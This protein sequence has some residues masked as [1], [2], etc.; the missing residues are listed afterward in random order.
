MHSKALSLGGVFRGWFLFMLVTGPLWLLLHHYPCQAFLSV[1]AAAQ[2]QRRQQ[3]FSAFPFT[4]FMVEKKTVVVMMMKRSS[5]MSSSSKI[6]DSCQRAIKN[7]DD[8]DTASSSNNAADIG[9]ETTTVVDD[10]TAASKDTVKMIIPK[11]HDWTVCMVPP[12]SSSTRAVWDALTKARQQLADPGLLSMAT[13]CEFALS[14]LELLLQRYNN[15][16]RHQP[17]QE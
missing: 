15:N 11:F 4:T 5:I 8:D 3:L 16:P 10:D 2:Q 9:I 1:T 13:A 14:I 7:D 17:R 12:P 6:D